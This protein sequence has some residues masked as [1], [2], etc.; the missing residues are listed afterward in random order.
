MRATYQV[1]IHKRAM[2]QFISCPPPEGHGWKT[3]NDELV[4]DWMAKP[5]APEGVLKHVQC[6]CKKTG[7]TK[8]TCSCLNSS[9][10]CT[11]LCMCIHCGNPTP[12]Q[13]EIDHSD[14]SDTDDD[15]L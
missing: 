1:A 6:K 9:L 7:C 13:K 14:T 2:C 15:E 3:V 11:D 8:K 10:P 5:L 4:F 12:V